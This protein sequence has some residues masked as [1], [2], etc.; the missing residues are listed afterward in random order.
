QAEREQKVG[1][2]VTDRVVDDVLGDERNRDA[3]ADSED[4][5]EPDD[6]ESDDVRSEVRLEPP[7][8]GHR[9]LAP[10]VGDLGTSGW[11]LDV[12]LGTGVAT[13]VGPRRLRPALWCSTF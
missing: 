9:T 2:L 11:V 7:E 6:G 3:G 5:G 13:G 8:G 12:L 10:G 1:P 4:R